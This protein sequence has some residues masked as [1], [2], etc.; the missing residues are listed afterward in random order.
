MMNSQYK[1]PHINLKCQIQINTRVDNLTPNRRRS[2][3][4]GTEIIALANKL[5]A[6]QVR[7][8]HKDLANIESVI[9][10]KM[11][12]IFRQASQLLKLEGLISDSDA[13]LANAIGL[14]TGK[15]HWL[16]QVFLKEFSNIRQ[17]CIVAP[18]PP[19][20]GHSRIHT[21]F[22]ALVS[23]N[24]ISS[25]LSIHNPQQL[26]KLA[27]KLYPGSPLHLYEAYFFGA[28][29]IKATNIH[30]P[31]YFIPEYFPDSKESNISVGY[32]LSTYA[33]H[34]IGHTIEAIKPLWDVQQIEE[35]KLAFETEEGIL[36]QAAL[37]GIHNMTHFIGSQPMT[38]V[39][40]KSQTFMTGVE[41]ELRADSGSNIGLRLLG[42]KLFDHKIIQCITLM[43]ILDRIFKYTLSTSTSEWD[44]VLFQNHDAAAGQIRLHALRKHG[45]IQQIKS[46]DGSSK[47]YLDYDACLKSDLEIINQ[48][49]DL[50]RLG[51]QDSQAYFS[52]RMDFFSE[53]L[54]V[55]DCRDLVLDPFYYEVEKVSSWLLAECVFTYTCE[56]DLIEM[57]QVA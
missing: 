11:S 52:K 38:H 39:N 1:N 55:N 18:V 43:D 21:G 48:L 50:D 14:E 22:I 9:C 25:G 13:Y 19:M 27:Q 35:I 51:L 3:F 40:K 29:V 23:E 16:K 6:I 26:V 41:E 28:D 54:Y 10:L 34:S 31:P 8:E 5:Q 32:L 37:V 30:H 7:Q 53:Y 42:A 2:L 24:A 12:K 46:S 17:P 4:L 36:A 20:H 44:K 45:A 56:L 15:W 57:M 49:E 47:Y 33:A